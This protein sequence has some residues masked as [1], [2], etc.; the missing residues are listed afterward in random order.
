MPVIVKTGLSPYTSTLF[1]WKLNR[2]TEGENWIDWVRTLINLLIK[3]DFPE[4]IV[5]ITER[6]RSLAVSI[7]ILICSCLNLFV[8]SMKS[9]Q[10]FRSHIPHHIFYV[11]LT[12]LSSYQSIVVVQLFPCPEVACENKKNRFTS[13]VCHAFFSCLSGQFFTVINCGVDQ[14]S[15]CQQNVW[16]KCQRH[17]G[18]LIACFF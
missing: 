7:L 6:K 8:F 1:D 17:N 14:T 4:L 10:M 13:F 3:N 11:Y 15:G 16:V 12:V 18:D 2:F 9:A 5:I